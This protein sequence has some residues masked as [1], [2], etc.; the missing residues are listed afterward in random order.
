LAQAALFE[1]TLGSAVQ[2]FVHDP[3]VRAS[4]G[5]AQ[6]PGEPHV[7]CSVGHAQAPHWQLSVHVCEPPEPHACE[8]PGMQTPSPVHAPHAPRTPFVHGRI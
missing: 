5:D 1:A 6:D 2:S 8:A 3:H 7:S 4:A